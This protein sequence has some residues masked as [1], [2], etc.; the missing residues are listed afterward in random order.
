MEKGH[1][2][3]VSE[4]ISRNFAFTLCCSD[5][6]FVVLGG[7]FNFDE[8]DESYGLVTKSNF[9]DTGA[10]GAE[11]RVTWGH[12]ENTWGNSPEFLIDYVFVR[13]NT[14]EL[15]VEGSS[16]IPERDFQ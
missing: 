14:E 7:D 2:G 13:S 3:V 11:K 1:R 12:P 16:S 6:D 8:T 4:L 5:S 9:T 10:G 15:H